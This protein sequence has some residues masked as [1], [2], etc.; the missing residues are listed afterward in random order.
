MLNVVLEGEDP[1]ILKDREY[2]YRSRLIFGC[3]RTR[4]AIIIEELMRS[5]GPVGIA[6]ARVST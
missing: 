4:L 5:M 2:D 1:L 6:N 3:A